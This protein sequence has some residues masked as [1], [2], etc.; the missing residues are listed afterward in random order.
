MAFQMPDRPTPTGQHTPFVGPYA[1]NQALAQMLYE[2]ALSQLASQRGQLYQRYGYRPGQ[3]GQLEVDPTNPY[4]EFQ[5]MLGANQVEADTMDEGMRQRGFDGAGFAA[6]AETAAQFNAGG[7]SANLARA[8]LSGQNELSQAQFNNQYQ[9]QQSTLQNKLG[10][11]EYALKN[12]NFTPHAQLRT[13]KQAKTMV[14]AMRKAWVSRYGGIMKTNKKGQ[15]F[16]GRINTIGS[17]LY[18][19]NQALRVGGRTFK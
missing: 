5:Q 1:Q 18:K 10:S 3:N 8:L 9:Y 11:A 13:Q 14:D 12:R 4:G 17:D 6:Q 19:S 15:N 7:R 2:Q 16:Q